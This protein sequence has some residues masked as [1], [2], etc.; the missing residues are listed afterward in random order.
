MSSSSSPEL[1]W[2]VYVT[3]L[4]GLLWV[5]YIVNRLLEQGVLA[6]IWDPLGITDTRRP[7]AQRMMAAHANGVENLAVF[8]PLA[9][10]VHLL[11]LGDGL[12]ATA[13]MLYFFARLGHFLV[14]T[15]AVPLL[16]V[17]LFLTGFACQAV[18]ALRLLGWL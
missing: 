2:L 5:P 6:G 7:W 16:R 18:L 13:V 17:L 1:T 3:A 9:L 15:F 10:A 11:G 14:F 4:T 8:A 12:T